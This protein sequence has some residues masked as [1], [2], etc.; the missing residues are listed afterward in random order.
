MPV[1]SEKT[2]S[3]VSRILFETSLSSGKRGGITFGL[4]RPPCL[5][6]S[7][8][9]ENLSENPSHCL[10]NVSMVCAPFTTERRTETPK[11]DVVMACVIRE[12]ISPAE[13]GG[14]IHASVTPMPMSCVM[15]SLRS[16]TADNSNCRASRNPDAAFIQNASVL[17]AIRLETSNS[18]QETIVFLV[19]FC[20]NLSVPSFCFVLYSSCVML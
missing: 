14:G 8:P 1:T 10:S 19:F 2:A 16:D 3:H 5:D 4:G 18:S 11:S 20:A 13:D 15:T 12:P 9:S 17:H 7:E 6:R